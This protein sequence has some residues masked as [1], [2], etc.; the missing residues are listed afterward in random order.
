VGEVLLF[1]LSF[2]LGI[3][4]P[5]LIVR[6]DLTRLTGEP[7]ARAWPEASLW[8]AVVVFGPLCLPV[9]F[10][11]TRRSLLGIALGV[12]WLVGAVLLISLPIELLARLFG[13]SE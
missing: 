12:A 1:T 13:I 11:R 10:I 4:V 5:A 8:A 6:R 2:A 7:L 3:A 9:H